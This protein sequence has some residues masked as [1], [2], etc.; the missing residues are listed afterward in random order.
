MAHHFI[1]ACPSSHP[2]VHPLQFHY[3]GRVR[4]HS[5]AGRPVQLHIIYPF[6]QFSISSFQF[7]II[8][9]SFVPVL[10]RLCR[11]DVEGPAVGSAE[12]Q[13]ALGGAPFIFIVL[14]S[15]DPSLGLE[16]PCSLRGRPVH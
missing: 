13:A 14:F 7:R 8:Q 16:T 1:S 5:H 2:A 4:E 11:W 6:T 12:S 10:P 3:V 15:I 9:P